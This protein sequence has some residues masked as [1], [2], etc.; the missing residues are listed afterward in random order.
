MSGYAVKTGFITGSQLSGS[1]S[2]GYMSDSEEVL[3][4]MRKIDFSGA[5]SG[6]TGYRK[7]EG[8]AIKAMRNLFKRAEFYPERR[9]SYNEFVRK[10]GKWK[11]GENKETFSKRSRLEYLVS[12]SRPAFIKLGKAYL[13]LI[14]KMKYDTID[15]DESFSQ[16]MR[17]VPPIRKMRIAKAKQMSTAFNRERKQFR[18]QKAKTIF[19]PYYER[20]HQ[21]ELRS[22][23]LKPVKPPQTLK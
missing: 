7:K 5:L 3:Y 6:E 2:R 4:L 14:K 22:T 16:L 9:K 1:N 18:P 21:I 13:T 10:Y 15:N 17:N 11:M 19:Q 12:S 23:K 8:E 20:E